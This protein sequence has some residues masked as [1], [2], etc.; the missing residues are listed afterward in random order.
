M[1]G[2]GLD[3]ER[4]G[5]DTIDIRMW[6]QTEWFAKLAKTLEKGMT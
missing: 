6:H 4:F 2:V 3:L 1:S 5:W